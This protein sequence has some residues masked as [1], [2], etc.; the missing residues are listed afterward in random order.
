MVLSC[1]VVAAPSSSC[2][3]AARW[4]LGIEEP[5]NE[6]ETKMQQRELQRE[7]WRE[8]VQSW[9]GLPQLG[10]EDNAWGRDGVSRRWNRHWDRKGG[11]VSSIHLLYSRVTNIILLVW[12]ATDWG[13]GGD[14]AV[15]VQMACHVYMLVLL[16][17]L[18]VRPLGLA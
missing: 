5:L 13:R 12:L 18:G 7:Q 14:L 2:V 8:Y 6:T 9:N 10:G 15:F 16:V 17:D 3:V 4:F 11:G 1:R